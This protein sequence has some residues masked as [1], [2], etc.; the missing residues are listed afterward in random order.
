MEAALGDQRRPS[1]F[2]GLE[3]RMTKEEIRAW[4]ERE[5]GKLD[6][7]QM[8]LEVAQAWLAEEFV[9]VP[10]KT[11]TAMVLWSPR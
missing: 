5:L 8:M 2:Q 9:E 10:P 7:E 11:C 6:V 3:N 4:Y 1:A